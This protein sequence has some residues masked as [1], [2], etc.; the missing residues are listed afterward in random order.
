MPRVK[1]VYQMTSSDVMASRRG[2]ASAL[3]SEY[4]LISIVFGSTL[5]MR[6]P[7]KSTYQGTPCEFNRMP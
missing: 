2:R 6:L 4:S 3:G 1:S 7:R 5:P